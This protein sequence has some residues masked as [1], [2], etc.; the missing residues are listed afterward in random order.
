MPTLADTVRQAVRDHGEAPG[1]IARGA[2]IARS[3]LS[4]FLAGK[5][6]LSVDS[7]ERLAGY[8]NLSITVRPLRRGKV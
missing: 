7:I 4:R 2:G 1:R 8:M 3:Q 6:G 5:R